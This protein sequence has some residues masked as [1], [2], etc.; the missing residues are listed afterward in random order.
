M[1]L[2]FRTGLSRKTSLQISL[3]KAKPDGSKVLLGDIAEIKLGTENYN[4]RSRMNGN[5]AAT[6]AIYQTPGTNALDVADQIKK[7]T[8]EL[9]QR[10]PDDIKYDVSLDTTL[11]VTEG[12][13]RDCKNPL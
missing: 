13:T 9:S 10:F 4:S 8:A 7:T 2:F 5:P 11:A 6:I 3:L 1:V 12:I